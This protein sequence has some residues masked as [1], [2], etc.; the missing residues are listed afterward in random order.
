MKKN[1]MLLHIS[2]L[3]SDFGIGD[4]GPNAYQFV[5]FLNEKEF[6]YW[7]ILPLSIN[8]AMEIHLTI[9]FLLLL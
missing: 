5:D 7:Q 3:P 6:S 4:F 2:S 8:P 1:G 9:Q